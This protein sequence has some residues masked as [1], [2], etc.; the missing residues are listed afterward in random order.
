[1][2]C[3]QS[4]HN[5]VTPECTMHEFTPE[6]L[7]PYKHPLQEWIANAAR[8]RTV[9]VRHRS[10]LE[11]VMHQF[12]YM[13]EKIERIEPYIRPPWWISKVEIQIDTTKDI[14]KDLHN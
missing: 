2:A 14:V 11:N 1:M 13:V 7:N 9:Q 10:N 6:C 5:I 3:A 12:P 4:A 8:V